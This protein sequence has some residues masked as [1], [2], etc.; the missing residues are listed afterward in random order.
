MFWLVN[1]C[2]AIFFLVQLSLP[3]CMSAPQRQMQ[4]SQMCLPGCSGPEGRN[5]GKVLGCN[6]GKPL[7]RGSYWSCYYLEPEEVRQQLQSLGVAILLFFLSP[8]ASSSFT[9][10][11]L[12]ILALLASDTGK[13]AAMAGQY[14]SG[15]IRASAHICLLLCW[16]KK[17]TKKTTK[18]HYQMCPV[19]VKK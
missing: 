2:T 1:R 17:T 16:G 3:P 14:R 19:S 9:L 4:G 7:K 15:N 5:Q 13:V 8:L 6:K 12:T 18:R 11:V 10:Y